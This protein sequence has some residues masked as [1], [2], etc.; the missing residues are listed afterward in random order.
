LD[1]MGI[2]EIKQVELCT[3]FRKYVPEEWQDETCPPPDDA[4][5]AKFKIEKKRKDDPILKNVKSNN[6]N[7]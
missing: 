4:V 5:L 3:K 6:N 2:K 1:A 7:D